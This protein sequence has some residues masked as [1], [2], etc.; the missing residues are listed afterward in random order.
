MV[1]R[2]ILIVDDSV[3]IRRSLT[4]ALAAEPDVEVVGTASN[5]RIALMRIPMFDPDVVAL[6]VHMPSTDTAETLTEIRTRHPQVSVV[7]LS[8]PSW[9][10]S[11]AA[12]LDALTSGAVDYVTKP[13]N[14]ARESDFQAF[15]HELVSKIR[16]CCS[17]SI[18]SVPFDHADLIPDTQNSTADASVKR[19]DVV[20]IGVST[21]GPNAL[22][23]VLPRLPANFPVPVLIVQHMPQM[24]TKLLAERLAVHSK[25]RVVEARSGQILSP[26]GAWI[27]PGDL[28]MTV[29]REGNDVRILTHREEPENSCRPS[30]DVLFRSVAQNYGSHV[31]AV[32]MTGMGKDGLRGC[33]QVRRQG[34]QVLVQDKDSAVIWGMPGFVADA[35]LADRIVPLAEL[36]SEIIDRVRRYRDEE[37]SPASPVSRTESRNVT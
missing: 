36:S 28:H 17:D 37:N 4:A 22:M 27:A 18:R 26:G 34:G 10:G 30:A 8:E 15:G 16:A 11:A 25:I 19:I 1:K 20:A 31:L 2:R 7:I 24:F 6:D 32:V 14:T 35:G 29:A 33:E 5:G 3:V 9:H 12:T 13:V 23:E 21:G